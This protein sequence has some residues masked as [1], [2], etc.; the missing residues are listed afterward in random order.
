VVTPFLSYRLLSYALSLPASYR[1]A[2]A[3]GTKV[4]KWILRR[5]FESFLPESI[6]TRTK[7]QFS[8]GSG[9]SRELTNHFEA[10]VGDAELQRAVASYPFLRSKEELAYFRLFRDSY[11]DGKAVDTVGRWN[12]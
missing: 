9:S 10:T 12:G 2:E 1:I 11:G 5:A 6:A 8:E 7:S 3:A 4:E